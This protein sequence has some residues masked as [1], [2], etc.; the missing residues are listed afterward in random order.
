[1]V[2]DFYDPSFTV[3][4]FVHKGD[5]ADHL[6]FLAVCFLLRNYKLAAGLHIDL[7]GVCLLLAPTV[8]PRDCL[9]NSKKGVWGPSKL[10][11]LDFMT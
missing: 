8:S 11:T 1:M 4:H 5:G 7:L 2:S 9:Q 3:S 6:V 10:R